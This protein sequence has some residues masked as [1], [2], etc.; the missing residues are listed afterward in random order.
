MQPRRVT[1]RDVFS[2]YAAC[3]RMVIIFLHRMVIIIASL[4]KCFITSPTAPSV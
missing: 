2:F 4:R 3:Y 1:T